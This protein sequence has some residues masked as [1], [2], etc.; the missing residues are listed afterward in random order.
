VCIQ[1][2]LVVDGISSI[3]Y[4]ARRHVF[5]K[6]SGRQSKVLAEHQHQT[7]AGYH[8]RRSY[9]PLIRVLQ[10]RGLERRPLPGHVCDDEPLSK[11]RPPAFAIFRERQPGK[12]QSQSQICWSSC[13]TKFPL[14]IGGSRYVELNVA[15]DV[16]FVTAAGRCPRTRGHIHG[17][18][19][20]NGP[21]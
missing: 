13:K 11:F 6:H 20:S 12:G 7:A 9:M 18:A 16:E 3:H 15:R 10:G 21:I 17:P 5:L 2:H 4:S 8:R 1:I 19:I 14:T